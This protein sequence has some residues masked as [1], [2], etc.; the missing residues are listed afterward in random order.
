MILRQCICFAALCLSPS[1]ASDL[2]A[3][4]P[5]PAWSQKV[6]QWLD[7]YERGE[8]KRPELE[9]LLVSQKPATGTLDHVTLHVRDLDKTSRLYQEVF[10]L[11][12]L[13]NENNTHYLGLGTSF[14]GLQ[15]SGDEEPRLDHFCL[16][17]PNFDPVVLAQ[18]L[19]SRGLSVQGGEP[20]TDTLRFV[21]LDGLSIQV[22]ATDYALKQTFQIPY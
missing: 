17:V 2:L 21:D 11:P 15:P 18:R 16:G 3:Q 4:A 20:G 13:R 7:R 8:L 22:C 12:L 5:A 1:P 9:Q 19:R 6:Q 14:L 10:G